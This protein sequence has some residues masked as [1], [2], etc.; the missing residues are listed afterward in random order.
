MWGLLLVILGIIAGL[1]QFLIALSDFWL[2]RDNALFPALKRRE[3][4]ITNIP[5][6]PNP[7]IT[8]PEQAMPKTHA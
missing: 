8:A 3:G 4:I 2:M 5:T 6:L 7:P 1:S